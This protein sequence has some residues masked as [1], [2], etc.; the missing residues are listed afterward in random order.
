MSLQLYISYLNKHIVTLDINISLR[1]LP[2]VNTLNSKW[3]FK[4]ILINKSQLLVKALYLEATLGTDRLFRPGGGGR[5]GVQ[6]GVVYQNCTLSPPKII[7]LENFTPLCQEQFLKST[8]PP[9][10]PSS[11]FKSLLPS[12]QGVDFISYIKIP[13]VS[14]VG[15]DLKVHAGKKLVRGSGACSTRKCLNLGSQKCHLLRFLYDIFSK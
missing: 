7:A 9:P 6:K 3:K 12:L 8:P 4:T 13:I 15:W 1:L 14:S 11:P 2:S 10:P 5:G